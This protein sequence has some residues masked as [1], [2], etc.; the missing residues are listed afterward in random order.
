MIVPI[1]P[2]KTNETYIKS[3]S[4]PIIFDLQIFY[5]IGFALFCLEAFLS[6]WVIQVKLL[7]SASLFICLDTFSW[8]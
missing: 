8:L 4:L 6:M 2:E 3:K 1:F 5:F 7:P